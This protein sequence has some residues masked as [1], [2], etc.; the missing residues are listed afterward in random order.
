MAGTH[1]CKAILMMG[2][3]FISSHLSALPLTFLETVQGCYRKCMHHQFSLWRDGFL[4]NFF[5]VGHLA[6]AQK[7]AT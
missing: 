7:V 5:F 1:E 2:L 3:I 4:M 6:C